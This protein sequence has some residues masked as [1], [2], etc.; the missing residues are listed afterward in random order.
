MVYVLGFE[1]YGELVL[2][3]EGEKVKVPKDANDI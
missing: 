3:K 2:L 1:V